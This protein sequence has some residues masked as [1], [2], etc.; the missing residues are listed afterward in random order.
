MFILT[1]SETPNERVITV[2][3]YLYKLSG[4]NTFSQWRVQDF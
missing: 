1:K 4:N 3:K 2:T